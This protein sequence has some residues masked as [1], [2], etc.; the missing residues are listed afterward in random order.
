MVTVALVGADGA[1]KTTVGRAL[2]AALGRPARYVYLGANP[3]SATHALPTTRAVHRIRAAR[4]RAAAGGPPALDHDLGPRTDGSLLAS[5]VGGVR[6]AGR[7]TNQVAEGTYQ[8]A[9]IH[10]HRRRGRVVVVD[11]W[12]TADHH[13]HELAPGARLGRARRVHARFIRLAFPAPDL[14]VVLDAPAE[15]LHA[16]KG[17]G[18]LAEVAHRREE[19]LDYL[20]TVGRGARVDA[21]RPLGEV[22]DAVVDAVDAA[23]EVGP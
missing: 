5:A 23:V 21:S 13:A 4:G 8:W 9:V 20:R 11:R 6:G 18:T 14:V 12:H 22:L 10:W 1:G 7:V 16:R 17:E 2:P 15:V 3:A 19:Y